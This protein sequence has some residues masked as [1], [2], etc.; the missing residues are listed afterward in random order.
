MDKEKWA[1]E[2]NKLD[3]SER[4]T[5]LWMLKADDMM[6]ALYEIGNEIFRPARKHGYNDVEINTLIDRCGE[7]GEGYCLASQVISLLEDKY[8]DIVNEY[9]VNPHMEDLC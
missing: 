8:Y 3:D 2:L 9:G 1:L 4:R 6:R 7:D 5:V